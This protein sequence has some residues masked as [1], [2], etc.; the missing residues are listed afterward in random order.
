LRTAAASDPTLA[1]LLEAMDRQRWGRMK[2]NARGLERC[3][4]LRR[5]T[6]VQR[7]A[8]LMWALTA[9]ELY[10]LFVVRRGWSVNALAELVTELMTVLL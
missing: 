4:F 1:P 5:G 9:P 2:K 7:A 10:D 8:D 3:G 6:S